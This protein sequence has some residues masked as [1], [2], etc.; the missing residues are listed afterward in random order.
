[1]IDK[2]DGNYEFLSNFYPSP[3]VFA[4]GDEKLTAETVEHYFQ[5][6]KT[7]SMEEG[8]EILAA[9]HPG[10]AKRLGRNCHLR[11]DWEEIKDEVM[12]FALRKKFSIPALR[13]KLLSTGN[14]ELVE[15]NYWHDNY[16]GVCSCTRCRGLNIEGKNVLGKLLMQVREE[17]KNDI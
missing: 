14:E 13:D 5:Y 4:E 8:L 16:W 7:P 11:S 6:V 9:A 1:M 2:F 12:L 15:G 3:F 17:V 10:K